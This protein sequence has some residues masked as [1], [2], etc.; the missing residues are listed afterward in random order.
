MPTGLDLAPRHNL[1]ITGLYSRNFT[2]P[3]ILLAWFAISGG[4]FSKESMIF[5]ENINSFC[6]KILWIFWLKFLYFAFCI[7]VILLQYD[8]LVIVKLSSPFP[9]SFTHSPESS[10]LSQTF[11][12][13]FNS[14]FQS[15]LPHIETGPKLCG[16]S[17]CSYLHKTQLD[18]INRFLCWILFR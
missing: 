12:L 3:L 5:K 17:V 18:L 2:F 7:S 1:Q 16:G 11:I 10:P 6:L 13:N 8:C 9:Y 4:D 14:E 15:I